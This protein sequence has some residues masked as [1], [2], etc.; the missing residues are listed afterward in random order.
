MEQSYLQSRRRSSQHRPISPNIIWLLVCGTLAA[1]GYFYGFHQGARSGAFSIT[2]SAGSRSPSQANDTLPVAPGIGDNTTPGRPAAPGDL[3]A[4][5]KLENEL[6]YTD[7]QSFI[8]NE[9]MD[10]FQSRLNGDKSHEVDTVSAQVSFENGAENYTD[11]RQN[12]RSRPTLSSLPGAW[13]E[14]EFGTLLRQTRALLSTQPISVQETSELDNTPATVYS[15][16][17]PGDESP[18]EL[19]VASKQYRLPF[20]T[21]V[22][23]EK[24]TG[25]I[26]KIARTTSA[27]PPA[28]GISEI[29]WSVVLKPVDLDGKTWLLPS[30][31]EYSVLY[32]NT[33]HREWNT[34]SFSNYHRY[35]SQSVIHF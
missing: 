4:R 22:W 32:Q 17:V 35:A 6:L 14:G 9:H 28:S 7:L 1:T 33:N 10:R 25:A 11:I 19:V 16:D 15:F 21:N 20:R 3:L 8:C 18:W 2:P 24:A 29:Q 30:T 31:G 26:M 5:A 27:I 34:I 12:D 23:V 13:S